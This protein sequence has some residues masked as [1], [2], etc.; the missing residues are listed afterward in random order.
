V[1]RAFGGVLV[2]AIVYS[3]GAEIVGLVRRASR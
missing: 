3:I 1:T 2:V